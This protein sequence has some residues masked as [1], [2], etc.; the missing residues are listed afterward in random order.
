MD[1]KSFP[2]GYSADDNGF[3]VYN[4][5]GATVSDLPVIYGFN[6][7]GSPGFMHAQLVAEDGTGLGSHLCSGVA[8]M[9]YDLGVASGYRPDRHEG[10]RAHYPNGYRM[11]FVSHGG[12]LSHPA[13]TKVFELN[14]A[15]AE[16]ENAKEKA[17]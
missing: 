7:G 14:K 6:N 13:L 4:P 17:A 12:V 5:K 11:E 15:Q 9:P 10:F 8:Y 3:A 2:E 1:Q 16:A